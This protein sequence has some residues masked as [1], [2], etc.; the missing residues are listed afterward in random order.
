MD[1]CRTGFR[2]VALVSLMALLLPL[3]V[4]CSILPFAAYLVQGLATP[5]E[6]DGLKHKRVAVICRPVASLQY[7][8]HRCLGRAGTI[9][10]RSVGHECL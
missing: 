7:Q 1:R 4:G 5:A 9:R 3:A 2:W 10:G 6:F 8:S